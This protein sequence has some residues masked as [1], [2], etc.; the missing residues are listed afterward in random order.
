[1]SDIKTLEAILA[2]LAVNDFTSQTGLRDAIDE[3]RYLVSE[4]LDEA[5]RVERLEML[6]GAR[7]AM[8]RT[9]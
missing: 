9:A 2:A 1:M 7:E 4:M 8:G 6:A 3:A 5:Q